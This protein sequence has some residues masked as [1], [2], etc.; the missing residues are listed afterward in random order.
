MAVY[1]APKAGRNG[2]PLVLYRGETL[3]F[4]QPGT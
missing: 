1:L 2:A 3:A 4:I